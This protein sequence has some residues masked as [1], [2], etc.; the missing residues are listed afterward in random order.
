MQNQD[1]V[2]QQV[3]SLCVHLTPPFSQKLTVVGRSYI[4][5]SRYPVC[6][7]YAFTI[8]RENHHWFHV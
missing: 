4:R 1:T 8:V 7:D 2:F 6:H 3:W 5:T